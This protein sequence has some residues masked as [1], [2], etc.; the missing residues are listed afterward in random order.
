M[1]LH[2]VHVQSSARFEHPSTQSLLANP[3][4]LSCTA[5]KEEDETIY[6]LEFQY[7][8]ICQLQWA[9]NDIFQPITRQQWLTV[10]NSTAAIGL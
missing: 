5:T 1:H 3:Q 6:K 2:I 10:A 8:V 4:T 7:F 9:S